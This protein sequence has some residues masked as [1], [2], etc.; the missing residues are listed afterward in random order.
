M[1]IVG[2]TDPQVMRIFAESSAMK[3]FLVGI[4]ENL[5]V[6]LQFRQIS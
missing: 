3:E 4:N 2:D 1:V 6:A 5:S